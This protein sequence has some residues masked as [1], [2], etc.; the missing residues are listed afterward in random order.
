MTK[1]T[2]ER[3]IAVSF[4][5]DTIANLANVQQKQLTIFRGAVDW[6][7]WN[8]SIY[9]RTLSIQ[10]DSIDIKNRE[11]ILSFEMLEPDDNGLQP[12]QIDDEKLDVMISLLLDSFRVIK[13]HN[14]QVFPSPLEEFSDAQVDLIE[15]HDTE[16]KIHGI[17][18][19]NIS[20][21]LPLSDE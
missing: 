10:V 6:V 11:L 8:F 7:A 17:V 19:S 15:M 2:N 9:G 14:S 3:S 16:R 20:V 21:K 12:S 18:A 13:S 4:I 5:K 1:F